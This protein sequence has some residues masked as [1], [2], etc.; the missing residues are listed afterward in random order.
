MLINKGS[1]ARVWDAGASEYDL[2]R[3]NDPVYAACTREAVRAVSV[4]RPAAGTVLDA[5]CGTGLATLALLKWFRGVVALDYS[6]DSLRILRGKTESGRLSLVK[7]DVCRLPFADGTFDAVLCAN[8]LQ[9]L[10]PGEPQH[11][12]AAELKRVAKDGAV[13][14]ATVHH[15]SRAKRR[16]GWIKEGKPGQAGIDYI[17][18]FSRAELLELFPGARISAVGS[19]LLSRIPLFSDLLQ[20]L[21]ARGLGQCVARAGQGHMLLAR[22]RKRCVCGTT[23]SAPG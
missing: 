2:L 7:A 19:N 9:H 22:L 18:R 12:A 21:L 3:T 10:R 14:V 13:I 4:G 23:R 16:L 20:A 6:F 1:S 5:G 11:Q 8:T 15:Y 17:F